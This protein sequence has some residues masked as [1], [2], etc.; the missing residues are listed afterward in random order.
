MLRR[1][2]TPGASA[3]K[4]YGARGILVCE[5]WHIFENFLTDMGE[6]PSNEHSIDRFPDNNG[7]YEAGNCRWATDEQQANNQRSNV[8]LEHA[9]ER[10]TI[11]Q[12]AR[13]T[14][15][16]DHA[17]EK[18]LALGWSAS[19]ALTQPVRKAEVQGINY[20]PSRGKWVARIGHKYIGRYPSKD[21][22]IAARQSMMSELLERFQ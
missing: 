14:G 4:K 10:M 12:W 17:I 7:D 8:F 13:K 18:R 11:A 16:K 19:K 2:E 22:A 6:P 21:A 1:C 5:R 20:E 3:F 15:I 9:G